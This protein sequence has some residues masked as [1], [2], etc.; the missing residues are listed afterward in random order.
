MIEYKIASSQFC[1]WGGYNSEVPLPI[2]IS[3]KILFKK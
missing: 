2:L 1:K 3:N